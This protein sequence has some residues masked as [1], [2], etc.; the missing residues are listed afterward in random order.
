[1]II[2]LFGPNTSD[3]NMLTTYQ[4]V[5]SL[6]EQERVDAII[7]AA[8]EEK[9]TFSAEALAE[10]KAKGEMLFA[11]ADAFIIEATNQDPE[12][13]YL[14]AFAALQKKPSLCLFRKGNSPQGLPDIILNQKSKTTG[15]FVRSYSDVSLPKTV[16]EFL[17]KIQRHSF[18]DTPEIKFTLRISKR[19]E[20][21]LHWKTHGKNESK[22]EYLR[23][24]IQE[25]IKTDAEY[26]DLH[27]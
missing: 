20:K 11:K 27:K 14:L 10:I 5:I 26:Q 4:R 19:M 3:Q 6:L 9:I 25:M 13:P 2:Y 16:L 1:M 22:A 8:G 17:N 23:D 21:Y 7:K 24:K 12:I 15:V 18:D